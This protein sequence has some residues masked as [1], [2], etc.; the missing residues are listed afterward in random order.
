M[1]EGYLIAY[2][3]RYLAGFGRAGLAAVAGLGLLSEVTLIVILLF[4]IYILFYICYTC[5]CRLPSEV[6]L[7]AAVHYVL[8]YFMSNLLSVFIAG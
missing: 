3:F 6:T 8:L 7:V 2:Y 1:C 4:V 5:Y